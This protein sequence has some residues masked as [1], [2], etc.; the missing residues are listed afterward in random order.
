MT[1]S[2]GGQYRP[3]GKAKI[4]FMWLGDQVIELLMALGWEPK[5]ERANRPPE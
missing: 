2:G 4:L 1:G 3:P 5:E